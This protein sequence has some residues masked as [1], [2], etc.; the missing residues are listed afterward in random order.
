MYL[1]WLLFFLLLSHLQPVLQPAF[2]HDEKLDLRRHVSD[3]FLQLKLP[4]VDVLE[5]LAQPLGHL[6]LSRVCPGLQQ[7]F[8]VVKPRIS[9]LF[10]GLLI[11]LI[12]VTWVDWTSCLA[13]SLVLAALFRSRSLWKNLFSLWRAQSLVSHFLKV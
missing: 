12:N 5:P 6:T 13:S 7:N 1:Q 4:Q 11:H 2:L 9:K 3:S 8:T 10:L